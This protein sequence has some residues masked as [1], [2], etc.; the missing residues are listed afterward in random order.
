MNTYNA[1]FQAKCPSNDTI[2]DYSLEIATD[3]VTIMVETL[4]AFL[5]SIGAGFHEAI[6]DMLLTRFGGRQRLIAT[7]H[8]VRIETTRG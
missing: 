7:H 1:A 8:G 4:N 6:A 5:D 3:N 2:I